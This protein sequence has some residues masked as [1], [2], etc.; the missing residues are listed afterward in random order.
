MS[1]VLTLTNKERNS[2]A[3]CADR[4]ESARILFLGMVERETE[5]SA[6]GATYDVPEHVAWASRDA[7]AEDGGDSWERG[8]FIPCLDSD[9]VRV[10][11][12]SIV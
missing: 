6:E 8:G 4:Y 10:L 2:L 7:I 3:W 12:E 1:Y 11:F 9:A 5:Y